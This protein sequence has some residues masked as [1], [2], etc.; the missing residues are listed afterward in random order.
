M[1]ADLLVTGSRGAPAEWEFPSGLRSWRVQARA[2]PLSTVHET[3]SSLPILK[4]VIA[5]GGGT[6]MDAA[7]AL[8]SLQKTGDAQLLLIPT[9]FGTGAEVTRFATVYD[10]EGC[11]RSLL[12][13]ETI[14]IQ[15]AYHPEFL[16]TLPEMEIKAGFCDAFAHGFESIWA[17]SATREST[18]FAVEALR[19]G[20]ECRSSWDYGK[21]QTMGRLAGQAIAISKTTAAH[22][23]SYEWT[24]K[25]GIP[26]GFAVAASLAALHALLLNQLPDQSPLWL[27]AKALGV[28]NPAGVQSALIHLITRMIPKEIRARLLAALQSGRTQDPCPD[29]LANFP[30]ALNRSAVAAIDHATCELLQ[31]DSGPTFVFEE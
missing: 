10:E 31:A 22:A 5:V 21:L 16:E 17:R 13:P 4:S 6:V 20:W 18:Q 9:T 27:Q 26:H 11:K 25:L 14:E 30:L 24:Q 19:I 23:L 29:R 1:R 2:L 7:K 28:C 8:L 3:L 15:V 12:L